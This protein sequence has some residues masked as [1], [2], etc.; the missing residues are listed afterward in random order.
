MFNS[1]LNLPDS[2][3]NPGSGYTGI[4]FNKTRGD[5]PPVGTGSVYGNKECLARCAKQSKRMA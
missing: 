1:L 4:N 3:L 2:L 5:V